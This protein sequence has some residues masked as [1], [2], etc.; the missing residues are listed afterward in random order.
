MNEDIQINLQDS[1]VGFPRA[2]RTSE[3]WNVTLVDT[4]HDT[5][6][7]ERIMN[8][9]SYVEAENFLCT[10]G[11]GLADINLKSLIEFHKKHGKIATVTTVRP[12]TRFGALEIDSKKEVKKFA[13][14]PKSEKWINGGFF[15]FEPKIFDYLNDD[16]VLEQEPLE[17]L[18]SQ[19]ELM[20][21]EHTGFWQPMDTYRETQELNQ[22]WENGLAPWKNW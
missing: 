16:C 9:R 12:T 8:I 13:E 7:A 5:L 20:A 15:I 10:Y 21:F 4:G 14:K 17:N 3:N 18:A 1:S 22:L 2:K 11:D 6:T 19:G